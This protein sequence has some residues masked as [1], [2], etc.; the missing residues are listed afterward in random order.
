MSKFVNAAIMGEEPVKIAKNLTLSEISKDYAARFKN[1]IALARVNN[2]LYELGK[3]LHEDCSVEFLDITDSNAF[4]AYQ[5]S[6]VFLLVYAV[7]EVLGR[8]SRVIVGHSINKNYY[9]EIDSPG[10]DESALKKT[11][12]VMR[13]LAA[14]KTP[15]EKCNMPIEAAAALFKKYAMFDKVEFLKY[16]RAT[17]INLYKINDFYDYFYGQ[18]LPDASFLTTF[19]LVKTDAGLILRFCSP[20][21]AGELNSLD[22]FDKISHVFTESRNWGK[23]L[24]VSNVGQLNNIITSGG[25]GDFIRTCEALHEKKIAH[26]ADLIRESGKRA[27]FIAGPSSSGK[28]TF[29]MR[30]CIQLRVNGLKPHVISLDNYFKNRNE[31]PLDENGRPDYENFDYMNTELLNADLTQLLSGKTTP[32]PT[33]DFYEGRTV[34]K[35][36]SLTLGADDILIL[37]GIH[38]L[39]DA[40]TYAIDPSVKFKIFISAL[41]Q[42]SIDDHNRITTTDTRLIRRIVRDNRFRGMPAGRTID[43]WPNV[44]KGERK[45]IFPYQETSDAIFNSALVYEMCVL[46]HYAEPLLFGVEKDAAYCAQARRLIKFLDSFLGMESEQIPNNSIL[47][48]FMGGSCF[49]AVNS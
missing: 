47:R 10:F 38:A 34:Y 11:D 37:E 40:L 13:A 18:L 30:L 33:Y 4:L 39:N 44:L 24:N 27:V 7:K 42:L 29:A 36:G 3:T 28:T 26:I 23:I 1:P 46:K 5:N 9:V 8:E 31:V 35:G 17:N 2:E 45:Y 43:M 20:D 19:E 15:I 6:L 25:F 22:A 49:S 32:A 14:N 16:R 48:E 21:N 41:T 12:A